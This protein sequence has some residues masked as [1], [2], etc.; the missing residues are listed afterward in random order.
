MHRYVKVKFAA[1]LVRLA[2]LALLLFSFSVQAV[3]DWKTAIRD[4]E[5]DVVVYQRKLPSG[6]TEFKGITHVKSSLS[7]CVALMR[8]VNAMP[9]WVDRT[10][11]AK[12]LHW[13]SDK[14]VYAYNVTRLEWPLGNRDAI[15]HTKLEQDP[16]SLAVTIT[17]KGIQQYDGETL[18]DYKF[19]E[20][21]YVRMSKV[22]S[23]W[24]FV[25][26][27]NGM[28]EV[29]FQGYGDPGGKISSGFFKWFLSL[30]V[31]ESP[32]ETLKKMRQVIVHSKYQN[33]R[34]DFI[35]DVATTD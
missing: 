23:Y 32:Y 30:V 22:E 14:E 4:T 33:A 24:R 16:E 21:K 29:T 8:D 35:K 20:H 18:Y 9:E 11:M 31:W 19:N 27:E 10:V 13:V 17:G 26:Q 25:P 28:V 15:V 34:F 6:D 2:G 1:W 5:N 12:V 3:D 7:A